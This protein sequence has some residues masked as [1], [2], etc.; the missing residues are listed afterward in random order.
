[1]TT[2]FSSCHEGGRR[3]AVS[4]VVPVQ[5][6]SLLSIVLVSAVISPSCQAFL[7]APVRGVEAAKAR[8]SPL[9]STAFVSRGAAKVVPRDLAAAA[10]GGRVQSGGR[11][12]ANAARLSMRFIPTDEVLSRNGDH[13]L[14]PTIASEASLDRAATTDPLQGSD[15]VQL[16]IWPH[17]PLGCVVDE[18]LATYDDNTDASTAPSIHPPVYVFVSAIKAGGHAERAGLR[19]GDVLVECTDLFGQLTDATCLG[20][21]KVYVLEVWVR[22]GSVVPV[23]ALQLGSTT[24]DVVAMLMTALL[25]STIVMDCTSHSVLL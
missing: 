3:T 24:Y 13:D 8:S 4:L 7:Q 6:L 25:R 22:P 20:V 19:V 23:S 1:M 14:R 21:E 17:G 11:S 16:S 5:K 10:S 12:H 9:P 2:R 15:L 18:S